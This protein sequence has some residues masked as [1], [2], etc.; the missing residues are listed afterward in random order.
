VRLNQKK[1]KAF[2]RF[3]DWRECQ[4]E[5]TARSIRTADP[6]RTT[7]QLVVSCGKGIYRRMKK[8]AKTK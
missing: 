4:Y 1:A 7:L 8:D 2:R 3:C 6:F 5:H